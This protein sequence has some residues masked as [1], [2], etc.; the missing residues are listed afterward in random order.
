MSININKTLLRQLLR[1]LCELD[2]AS[3][4]EDRV[5]EFILDKIRDKCECRVTPLGCVIA[6]Y[7]G[8]NVPAGKLMISA[9]MDE[10]GLIV[11]GINSDGTLNINCIGGVEADAVIGRQVRLQNGI[12]GAVGS[13]AVHNMSEEERKCAPKFEGLYID[14]GAID[15]ADAE[16]HVSLGDYAYFTSGFAEKGGFIRS[17]AIDDRAGCAIML[18]MIL[19]NAL[20]YDCTFTFVTQEEIGLRGARTAAFDVAPDFALVLEATTAADIP[21][22][23]GDKRCCILGE[24]P[25]VSYMDRSTLYDRG[26]YGLSI[27]LAEDMGIKRQTKTVIAGGN[28]SGAIHISR[29]GVRTCAV[30]VPCRYLHTPCCVINEEDYFDSYALS[31]AMAEKILSGEV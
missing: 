17:K 25:V 12:M 13:K 9:H 3:G 23:E 26:L 24:G 14:I 1:E 28:D 22:S 20:S 4:Q 29:G 2:G 30:S 19:D 8:G 5:R 16:K 15:R 31:L 11:T 21:L 6:E 7:K 10:V 27:R 18:A